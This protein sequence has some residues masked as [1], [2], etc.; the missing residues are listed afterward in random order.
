MKAAK[1]RASQCQ[2]VDDNDNIL[3]DDSSITE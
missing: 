1:S 3:S 2:D